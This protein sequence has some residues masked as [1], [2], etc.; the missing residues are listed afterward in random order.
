[1]AWRGWGFLVLSLGIW[2]CWALWP[3]AGGGRIVRVDAEAPA[4]RSL[5]VVDVGGMTMGPQGPRP[6]PQTGVLWR[7]SRAAQAWR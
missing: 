3:A 7:I 6:Q 4:S 5:Q 2:G 1:M